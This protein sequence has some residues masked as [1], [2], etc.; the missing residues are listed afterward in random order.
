MT[1]APK[2]MELTQRP[3]GIAQAPGHM[4]I[5]CGSWLACEG[6]VSV[7]ELAN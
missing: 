2:H 4:E 1:Q 3:Q 7:D 5:K 6:G